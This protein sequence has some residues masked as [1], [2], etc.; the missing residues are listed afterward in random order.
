MHEV[1]RTGERTARATATS[2]SIRSDEGHPRVLRPA[3]FPQVFFSTP[4]ENENEAG[5]RLGR[6]LNSL[7]I[8][9]PHVIASDHGRD[10][11]APLVMATRSPLP[12]KADQRWAR[13]LAEELRRIRADAV[14]GI[15]GG[16]C[17]DVS[18]LVASL[19]GIPFVSVPT[20]L[21]HDGICSPVAVV[22]DPSTDKA[23]LPVHGPLAV[24]ISIPTL[25]T[26]PLRSLRAG[27]GDIISNPLAL[28]DWELAATLGHDEIDRAGWELS[29]E[30]YHLI[31]PLLEKDF[32]DS[33]P[34]A[35]SLALLANALVVSGMSMM[36]S[37]S[38]RPASG[39]EHKISH[40][41]DEVLG[42]RA[43]HGEQVAFGC[44]ISAALHQD[45]PQR[46]RALL[47]R[48]RLPEHP[49]DLGLTSDDLVAVLLGAPATRPRFTI[50][51]HTALDEAG[52]RTLI[53]SIWGV[54][55]Q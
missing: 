22:P 38:S 53:R 42:G 49:R 12:T 2:I 46:W 9:A 19:S 50:L 20:Q 16:S 41:I 35:E 4:T 52:A 7:G 25:L 6:R 27:V 39:A 48:L 15:G 10:L 45:D 37:R 26:A 36:I 34:D 24:F 33:R 17:L 18:K 40:A 30:S 5:E 1:R 31:E 14:V 11:S 13:R 54:Y 43:L 32:L 23:S 51:E 21:S 28:R 47:R 8:S 44:I 3:D 55:S 29:V